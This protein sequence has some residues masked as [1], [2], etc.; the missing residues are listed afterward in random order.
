[1][2]SVKVTRNLFWRMSERIGAK[3]VEFLVSI[4][5]ARL[6]APEVYGE[7]ALITIF[8]TILQVFV[9][10]GLGS[11]LIQKKDADDIDFSTVFYFNI[12]FCIVLYFLLFLIAP[13]I[14]DFYNNANLTPIIRVLGLTIVV[15]GVKNVQQAYVS[16]QM[17]FKRFFFATLGGTIGAALVGIV[18]AYNGFG[19]WALVIQQLFNVTVDTIILW[20]TVSWKPKKQ[21][22]LIRLKY[23]YSYGWRLLASNLLETVYNEISQLIIG[24]KYS[25]SDLAYYNRA[26]QFPQ[27][28]TSNINSSIN[29]VLFPAMSSV[30]DNKIRLKSM[31]RK[32]IKTSTYI[33]A[34]FMV[35]IAVCSESLVRIVLTEKWL[36]VVP[37]MIIFCITH[38]FLPIHTANL[39]AIK[40]LGRSDIYLKLEIIKKIIGLVLLFTTMWFGVMVMAYSALISS[41]LSQI[42][43]SWPNRTLLDYKYIDQI[44]DILPS[45]LISLIMGAAVYCIKFIG[46]P[47]IITL[48]VQVLCGVF[49]YIILSK[50][51]HID[52]F[53]YV[54]DI[55]KRLLHKKEKN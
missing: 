40:A 2:D 6:L 55:I 24:K 22:S 3:G 28:V 7:I 1:M 50:L 48:V 32:A 45:L 11:A 43:N 5:L 10:G 17:L 36:P 9:D 42:I 47:S 38:T 13:L 18:L 27:F 46:L 23:L 33:I 20:I 4:I 49:L 19:I 35:G 26:K 29:S 37:F 8:I 44:K 12:L 53:E 15:S 54:L 39:N 25:S 34:P 51:F 21:F 41:I 31:T 16:K 52:S 30:Q 14:A